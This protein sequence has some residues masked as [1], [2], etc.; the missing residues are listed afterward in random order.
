[1]HKTIFSICLL[2]TFIT[3]FADHALGSDKKDKKEIDTSDSPSKSM[4]DKNTIYPVWG[5]YLDASAGL[6]EITNNNLASEIWDSQGDLGYSFNFGFFRSFG[7]FFKIKAGLGVSSFSNSLSGNGEVPSQ[8]FFDV[9]NDN[10]LEHLTLTN[11][12]NKSNP[13]YISAPVLLEFGNTNVS[14]VGYYFN[15][16]INYSYL[17]Y[18]NNSLNGT[19][20]SSGEYLQWGVILED[21]PELGFYSEKNIASDKGFQKTNFSALGGAGITIPISGT[22]IFKIGLTGAYGFKDIGNSLP[23]KPDESSLS[24]ASYA[25]RSKYINNTL[26]VNKGTKTRYVGIEFGLYINKLV[27]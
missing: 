2:F 12:E 3:A 11:I 17:I 27:K 1:M 7:P 24:D 16:G 15:V 20:T 9:D 14:K 5:F 21:I 23:E 6:S 8:Q 26:A 19:Y 13:M 18:E 10:Y 4:I 25:F 22:V